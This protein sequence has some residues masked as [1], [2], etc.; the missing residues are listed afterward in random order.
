MGPDAPTDGAQSFLHNL[1]RNPSC[2]IIH[3]KY[4]VE[5]G[6]HAALE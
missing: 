2:A 4:K 6:S 1:I 5:N 3:I